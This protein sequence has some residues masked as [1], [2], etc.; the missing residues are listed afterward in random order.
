MPE[1]S[2][3]EVVHL[4]LRRSLVKKIDHLAVD[5]DE[6][7]QGMIERLLDFSMAYVEKVGRLPEPGTM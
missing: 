4:K 3:K 2:D 6:Y 7:R 5:E 1:Q